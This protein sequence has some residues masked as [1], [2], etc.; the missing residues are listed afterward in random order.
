VLTGND[1]FEVAHI[2]PYSMINPSST[3][4][5][6]YDFW[7]VLKVFWS[8]DRIQK[9]RD[10]IFPDRR[11]QGLETCYNLLC[12]S[13]DAHAYW[14]KACFVLKPI[15]LSDDRKRLDVKF[16]WTPKYDRSPK[17]IL[18]APQSSEGSDS[19]PKKKL[20]HFPTDRPICSG[21]TISLTTDDPVT[22]PLPHWALLEMQW[23]LHRL[24]AMR[25]GAD[26]FDNDDDD[27]MA[28][29]NEWDQY[30]ENEWDSYMEDDW[31]SYEESTPVVVNEPSPSSSPSQP[32]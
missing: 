6:P 4:G 18:T 19:R 3:T 1:T 22:Q 15:K 7:N 28:L 10:A 31:N 20:L 23:T 25:G 32:S 9:W 11:D 16:Y 27:L 29:R 24:T 12:L 8:D 17:S 5:S 14:T 21:D 2:Y 13:P 30:K 26:D